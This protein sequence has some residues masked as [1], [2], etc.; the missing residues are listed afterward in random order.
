ML[1]AAILAGVQAAVS[2]G[3]AITGHA[4][5]QRE[6]DR[7]EE[8]TRQALRLQSR[9]LTI[10]GIEEVQAAAQARSQAE[11][12]AQVAT[13]SAQ[14]S[15]ASAGV[16]GAS[17]DALVSDISGD[18]GRVYQSIDFNTVTALDQ[19]QRMREGAELEA[20][21]RLNSIERPSLLQTLL[22]VGAG[23]LD[24]YSTYQRFARPVGADQPE[25]EE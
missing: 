2:I 16:R 7:S 21:S 12:Q 1:P 19:I 13:G 18:L 23:G 6:A 4:A 10:R 14:V 24:A 9:D 3:G 8:A 22:R 15:A 20:Q 11:R 25:E 5:R 17:V